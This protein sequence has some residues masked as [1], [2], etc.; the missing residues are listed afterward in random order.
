[1]SELIL[2]QVVVAAVAV[3]EDTEAAAAVRENFESA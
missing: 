1:M 2:I 3:A